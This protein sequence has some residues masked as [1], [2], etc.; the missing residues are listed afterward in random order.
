MLRV[1]AT[2]KEDFV[3]LFSQLTHE[4]T[5]TN[6]QSETHGAT[7]G[8]QGVRAAASRETASARARYSE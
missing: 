5:L 6:G 4:R 8:L 3:T 7:R 2:E 1:Y